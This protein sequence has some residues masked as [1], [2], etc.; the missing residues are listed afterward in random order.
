MYMTIECLCF[1]KNGSA[2]V[3][4][5]VVLLASERGRAKRTADFNGRCLFKGLPEGVYIMSQLS[6]PGTLIK[7]E[8]IHRVQLSRERPR[9]SI[10]F[11]SSQGIK[12][13]APSGSP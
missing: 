6:A 5:A 11:A 1:M 7:S 13:A 9:A 10:G 8:T 2:P 4:G 12:R 3:P